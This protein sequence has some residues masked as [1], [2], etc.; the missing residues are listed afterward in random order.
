MF[1]NKFFIDQKSFLNALTSIQPI[2]TKRTAIDSTSYILFHIR[3]KELVLKS[4]DLE[5]SL[6]TSCLIEDSSFL[7]PIEFLVPGKRLFDVVKELDGIIEC[8]FESGQLILRTNNDQSVNISLNIKSAEDFPIFPD[9]IE[10]IMDL[11]AQLFLKM[12]QNISFLIPQ[13]NSNPV[14]NSL[15]L[16]IS[17]DNI[18]LT[19]TDGHCLAQIISEK[20]V[21][22]EK[23]SWILSKRAVFELKKILESYLDNTIFLGISGSNLVFSGQYFNFFTKVLLD[24]FPKYESILNK[25]DFFKL[26]VDRSLFSKSLKRS[27]CFLSGQFISTRFI[28]KDNKLTVSIKNNDVGSFYEELKI[29]SQDDIFI[30]I[31]F[32]SPYLLNG[33]QSFNS[34]NIDFYLKNSLSPIIFDCYNSDYSMIYLVMPISPDINN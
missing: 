22:Y 11:D 2:C 5:I 25:D 16:E 33:L 32:Y 29:Q 7:K 34:D 9:I 4:T 24:Q 31:R 15:L 13:N 14:L 26:S 1:S 27:L 18:K 10:N 3:Q 12:L 6:Q 23:K 19:T 20:I 17:K 8:L 30:D 28:F 21:Y